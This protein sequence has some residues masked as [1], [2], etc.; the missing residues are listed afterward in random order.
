MTHARTAAVTASLLVAAAC[1]GPPDVRDAFNANGQVI[2]LSGGSA[3]AANACASCHGLNGEGD[4]NLSPRLA[5]LDRGYLIRQLTFYVDGQR[6]DPRMH[7]D[8][9]GADAR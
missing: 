6:A 9:Q 7:A 3:G 1:S 5:G 2:A 4:G 8:R